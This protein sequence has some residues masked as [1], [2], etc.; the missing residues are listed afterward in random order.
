MATINV[1]RLDAEVVRRLKQR[2]AVSNRSLESEARH[3]LECAAADDLETRRRTFLDLVGRLQ[4][5]GSSQGRT[6]CTRRACN[7]G[8]A[9]R[10]G[11]SGGDGCRRPMTPRGHGRP[12]WSAA[13][14]R[15]GSADAWDLMRRWIAPR[16]R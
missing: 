16:V 11:D 3:I 4:Q 13:P 15:T 1:R 6:S 12:A 5:N 2:A 9:D 8:D 7:R 10:P 14:Q